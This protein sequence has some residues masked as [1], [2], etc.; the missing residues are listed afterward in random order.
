MLMDW[1]QQSVPG[2]KLWLRESG[3]PNL[4]HHLVSVLE[5]ERRN[6]AWGFDLVQDKESAG[7]W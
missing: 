2:E 7:W 5:F 3:V 4:A 1:L 6:H